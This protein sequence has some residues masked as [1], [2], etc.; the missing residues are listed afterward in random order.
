MPH[1]GVITVGGG[2]HTP[3]VEIEG[4]L[5]SGMP[6]KERIDRRPQMHSGKCNGRRDAQWAHQG[7]AALRHIGG[8][9]LDLV[10]DARSPLKEG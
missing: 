6:F 10:R 5:N 9:L 1:H 4:Q 8:C 3:I 7:A 2:V